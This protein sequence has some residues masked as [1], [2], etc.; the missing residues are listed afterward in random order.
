MN[1]FLGGPKG[2]SFVD[3]SLIGFSDIFR[4]T[5]FFMLASSG[6]TGRRTGLPPAPVPTGNEQVNFHT[7]TRTGIS[8][9]YL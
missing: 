9:R 5:I 7:W 2:Y 8:R 1:C 3:V 6:I 4:D